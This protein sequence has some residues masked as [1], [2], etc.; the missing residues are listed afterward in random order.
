MAATLALFGLPG[1][2]FCSFAHTCMDGHMGHPPYAWWHFFLD[3]TWVGGFVTAAVVGAKSNL[4]LRRFLC[5]LFPSLV[6]SRLALGSLGG[7]MILLELPLAISAGVASV[8]SLRLAGFD[9]SLQDEI[10]R[11]QHHR[12]I[13]QRVLRGLV[14]LFGTI[15]LGCAAVFVWQ[16]VRVS[17]VPQVAVSESALPLVHSLPAKKNACVWLTLPTGKRVALWRE[18]SS[19]A[20][21]EWGERPYRQPERIW[22]ETS[23]NSKESDRVRSYMQM[24]LDSE[25]TAE[26]GRNEYSLFIGDF[27]VAWLL[28]SEANNNSDLLISV[29]R[30]KAVE[31]DNLKQKYGKWPLC[32]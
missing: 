6:I 14:A 17:R 3:V 12:M 21:P 7:M 11:A 26:S 23:R 4:V 18:Y 31:L 24:G 13:R 32:E 5:Y 10:T 19:S 15:S 22:V 30:A 16:V 9:P 28:K 1:F 8:R 29:R 20:Y 2:F 27:C 25:R